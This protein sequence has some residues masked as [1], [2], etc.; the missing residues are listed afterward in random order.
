M[1]AND[2]EG[3][4][5]RLGAKSRRALAFEELRAVLAE[6]PHVGRASAALDREKRVSLR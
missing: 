6:V 4:E 5:T 1:N 3:R 2:L